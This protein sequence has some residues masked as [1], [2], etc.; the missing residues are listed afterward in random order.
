MSCDHKK[1]FATIYNV[2]LNE[3]SGPPLADMEIDITKPF[4]EYLLD[5]LKSH[6]EKLIQ[7]ISNAHDPNKCATETLVLDTD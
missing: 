5:E 7:V 2:E 4:G 3:W 6:G 1:V